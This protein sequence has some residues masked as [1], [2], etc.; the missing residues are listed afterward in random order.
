MQHIGS[1]APQ[2]HTGTVI[3]TAWSPCRHTCKHAT[4]PCSQ[5]VHVL[6]CSTTQRVIGPARSSKLNPQQSGL[7]TKISV[8]AL[9]RQSHKATSLSPPP[10]GLM[11][12]LTNKHFPCSNTCVDRWAGDHRTA[13][14][15]TSRHHTYAACLHTT[16]CQHPLSKTTR[17]LHQ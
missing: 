15:I 12:S 11:Q 1:A 5:H 7:N 2:S 9:Q 14:W 13:G 8:Q 17:Y 10:F 16:S 4:A 6:S 3:A